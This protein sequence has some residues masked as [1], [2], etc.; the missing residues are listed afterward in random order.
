M[1]AFSWVFVPSAEDW[2][3]CNR[4]RYDDKF[5]SLNLEKE[6]EK[7]ARDDSAVS[8]GA[9]GAMDSRSVTFSSV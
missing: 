4:D 9:T 7:R 1:I 5:P 6:K 2:P 8:T 3:E